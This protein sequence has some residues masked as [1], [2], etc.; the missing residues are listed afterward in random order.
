MFLSDNTVRTSKGNPKM[1]RITVAAALF[2]LA[3]LSPA[4]AADMK[5]DEATMTMMQ[6]DMNKMSDQKAKEAAMKH[7]EMAKSSMK[8]NKMDDCM[9]HL[10]EA[11]KNMKKT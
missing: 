5:C 8:D 3:F 10:K 11:E 6:D 7:M 2:G 9:M 4:S 1:L